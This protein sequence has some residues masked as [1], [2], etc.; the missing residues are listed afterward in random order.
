ME[1]SLDLAGPTAT[2]WLDRPARGN[3]LGPEL[4]DAIGDAVDGARREG[5]RLLVLRGRGRNFCTGLDLSDFEQASEGDLALRII[6]IELLLQRIHAL[7]ITTMAVAQGR[8]FGAGADLFV[9][10]DHRVAVEGAQFS[11]PGPAFG[12]VLGTQRLAALIGDGPARRVLLAGEALRAAEALG[13]GLATQLAREEELEAIIARTATSA[14]R[15][16][17]E[18]VAALHR[19]TRRADDAGDLAAL[20]RS[21]ARPGLKERIAAYRAAR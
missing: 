12:L 9:A 1:A 6:R 3:A 20:A 2:I 18:T 16:D 11:F 7:P 19:R 5:A 8:V 14:A 21:V 13:M 4:V 15:L 17:A 10:C